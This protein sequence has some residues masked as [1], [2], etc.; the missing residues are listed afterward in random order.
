MN[1]EVKWLVKAGL[2]ILGSGALM[3]KFFEINY[4]AVC[5]HPVADRPWSLLFLASLFITTIIMSIVQ[6]VRYEA[7]T[8]FGRFISSSVLLCGLAAVVPLISCYLDI[9]AYG[10]LNGPAHVP[11][12]YFGFCL[13][14]IIIAAILLLT[15]LAYALEMAY[16]QKAR[17]KQ[18]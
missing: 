7:G 15:G 12:I 6:R 10:H 16:Q 3:L 8:I 1:K 11:F 13:Y 9:L 2:I 18:S 14:V 4:R 17:N 5:D